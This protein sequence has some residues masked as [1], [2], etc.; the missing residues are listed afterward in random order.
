MGVNLK[1]VWLSRLL[2]RG[3]IP[4]CAGDARLEGDYCMGLMQGKGKEEYV[5]LASLSR[6]NSGK[7]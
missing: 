2:L 1:V 5:L 4:L 3:H 6:L 7:A